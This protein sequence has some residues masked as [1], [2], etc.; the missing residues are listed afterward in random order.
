M[1]GD[2]S[3]GRLRLPCLDG[4]LLETAILRGATPLSEL[5]EREHDRTTGAARDPLG[6]SCTGRRRLL[7]L[8]L[9]HI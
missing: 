4:E 2:G 5:D 9:I 3:L 7:R 1:A 8:S 6:V